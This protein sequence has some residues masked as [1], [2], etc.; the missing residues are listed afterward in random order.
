MVILVQSKNTSN[1]N[2]VYFFWCCDETGTLA[3]VELLKEHTAVNLP[4]SGDDTPHQL[5][6][7]SRRKIWSD[8]KHAFSKPYTNLN[9]P[10]R[11]IFSG[12]EAAD[13]GGP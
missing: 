4:L 6:T 12:E 7:V 1:C 2:F 13:D 9:L 8:V 3:L 10:I 5:I 11:V